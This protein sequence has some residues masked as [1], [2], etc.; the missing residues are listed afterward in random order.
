MRTTTGVSLSTLKIKKPPGF[1]QAAFAFVNSKLAYTSI[2]LE[3]VA[4][5]NVQSRFL[6]VG[7]NNSTGVSNA[8]STLSSF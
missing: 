2:K 7:I 1:P 3:R 8:G 6:D 5:A 4:Q